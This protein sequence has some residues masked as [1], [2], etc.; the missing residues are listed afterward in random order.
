MGQFFLFLHPDVIYPRWIHARVVDSRVDVITL[1][2][3]WWELRD[4]HADFSQRWQGIRNRAL[5]CTAML[6]VNGKVSISGVFFLNSLSERIICARASFTRKRLRLLCRE[7]LW[8]KTLYSGIEL[9]GEFPKNALSWTNLFMLVF[10]N[11]FCLFGEFAEV[12]E[13]FICA[14]RKKVKSES[15]FSTVN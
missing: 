7:N 10:F 6:W 9:I 11:C 13:K 5:L 8:K 12:F 15:V 1:L 14:A 3:Q 4:S 2:D